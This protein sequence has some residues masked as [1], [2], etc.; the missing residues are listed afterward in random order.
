MDNRSK[1]CFFRCCWFLIVVLI[2][3]CIKIFVFGPDSLWAFIFIGVVF[4]TFGCILCIRQFCFPIGEESTGTVNENTNQIY[5]VP[6]LN[7]QNQSFEQHQRT[8]Q[9]ERMMHTNNFTYANPTVHPPTFKPDAPP[10]Y[11]E[12]ISTVN[13][14]DQNIPK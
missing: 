12:A 11:E 1:L 8:Y 5:T 10:S 9:T 2:F 3:L 6:N 4:V 13:L 7:F 14:R